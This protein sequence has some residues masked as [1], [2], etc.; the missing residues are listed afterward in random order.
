MYYIR[1]YAITKVEWRLL[2][3]SVDIGLFL[4]TECRFLFIAGKKYVELVVIN[5]L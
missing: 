1:R 4:L 2:Y 5:A 3:I